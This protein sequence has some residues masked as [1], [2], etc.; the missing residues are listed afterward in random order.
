MRRSCLEIH[1]LWTSPLHLPE[2]ADGDGCLP[3]GAVV[4]HL[5]QNL[6]S[7]GGRVPRL[8]LIL[9]RCNRPDGFISRCNWQPVLYEWVE[10]ILASVGEAAHYIIHI[11]QC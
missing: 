10:V 8:T 6:R 4:V 7:N 11:W 2:D 1:P 9:H 5:C 3:H